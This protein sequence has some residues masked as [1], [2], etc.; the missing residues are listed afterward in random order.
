MKGTQRGIALITAM[1][2]VAIIAALA[3]SLALGQQIWLRQTQNLTDLAQ[4]EKIRQGALEFA[5]ALLL[6][7]ARNARTGASD[8]L[9]EDWAQPIPPLPVDGGAVLVQIEDAQARFNLNN[10]ASVP[11]PR[12]GQNQPTPVDYAAVYRTL[13]HAVGIDPAAVDTLTDALLDWVDADSTVRPNGAEDLDYLSRDPPYRAANQALRSVDELRLVKGYTPEIIEKLRPYV[14]TICSACSAANAQVI[15]LNVNTASAEVL[16]A[17]FNRPL[18][19]IEP[20]L[21]AREQN[22]FKNVSEVHALLGGQAPPTGSYDVKSGYFIVKVEARIG[23]IQRRTEAL[24]ERIG[25]QGASALWYR[26][27]S[28]QIVVDEDKS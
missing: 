15:A 11:V 20:V 7:D 24:I 8:N 3:T 1:L 19:D 10:L 4:A 23:R 27:P 6:R 5:A 13:L 21:R 9:T 18:S 22:P 12:P 14:I 16:A 26:Q 17:F 28:F 25:T 2:I